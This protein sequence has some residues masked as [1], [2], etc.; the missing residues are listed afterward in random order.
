MFVSAKYETK[1]NNARATTK[2][3]CFYKLTIIDL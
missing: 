1:T 3:I 2:E